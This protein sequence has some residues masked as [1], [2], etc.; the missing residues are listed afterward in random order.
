MSVRVED[1][2]WKFKMNGGEALVRRNVIKNIRRGLQQI[3]AHEKQET[4]L[5]IAAGG[6]SLRLSL[7]EIR[8]KREQGAKLVAVNAT[9]DYMLNHGIQPSAQVILDARPENAR[10]VDRAFPECKYFVASQAH[11]SV[12]EKLEAKGIDPYLWHS[13]NVPQKWRI[14]DD[15]YRGRWIPVVGG[16]TVA[17]RAISLFY[18]LGYRNMDVYGL[19]SCLVDDLHHAYPQPENDKDPHKLLDLGKRQF[20]VAPWHIQQADDFFTFC[21][22]LP[23][24]NITVHGNGLIAYLMENK[25]GCNCLDDLQEGKAEAGRWNYRSIWRRYQN[26]PVHQCFKRLYRYAIDLCK[27]I[28][29]GILG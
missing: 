28:K 4:P 24:L 13:V 1:L 3:E 23:D 6:P 11:P 12:I 9:H 19:D 22:Q 16:S 25:N 5:I 20:W 2:G 14:L 8:Q 21:E 26:G 18:L 17:L 10:F 7:D 29:S 27:R 15:Y